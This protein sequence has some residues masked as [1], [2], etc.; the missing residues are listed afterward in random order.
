LAKAEAIQTTCRS[1]VTEATEK[2]I[3]LAENTWAVFST[4]MINT[5]QVCQAKNM[6]Q[7]Q[8]IKSGNM[9]SIN[10]GCYVW[11]MDHMILVNESETMEIQKKTM[12]WT[13]ELMES[14]GRANTEGIH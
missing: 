3:D 14:F 8:Q 1:K 6:I 11:T 2:I 12:D 7:T 13:G 9:V 5:N 4:G 10:P